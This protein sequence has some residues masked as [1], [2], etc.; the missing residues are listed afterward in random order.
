MAKPDTV[1]KQCVAA[2]ERL[3][4]NPE[5]AANAEDGE[6]GDNR[7]LFTQ[8]DVILLA[9]AEFGPWAE[10]EAKLAPKEASNAMGRLFRDRK[11]VRFGPVTALGQPDYVRLAAHIVYAPA[12]GPLTVK[13][14]NG[15]FPR[16][17]VHEDT[18]AR[19]GRRKDSA[20]TDF[21]LWADQLLDTIT[22]PQPKAKMPKRGEE[23]A[24]ILRLRSELTLALR[25]AEEAES[26]LRTIRTAFKE[27]NLAS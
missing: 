10:F 12:D 25:R 17:F 22:T 3:I 18:I 27:L 1:Y 20:R 14:P 5:Q 7:G 2:A 6:F 8:M 23:R 24:E 21:E 15:T 26:E 11:V 19:A 13:T 9:M 4:R 16:M